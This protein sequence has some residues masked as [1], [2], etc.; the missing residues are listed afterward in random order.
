MKT[1]QDHEFDA[2]LRERLDQL[3]DVPAR[4]PEAV[5]QGR[6]NYLSKVQQLSV[7]MAAGNAKF[8]EKAIPVSGFARFNSW[9]LSLFREPFQQKRLSLAVALA[10]LVLTLALLLGSAGATVY[11]AQSSLPGDFLYP[12]KILSEDVLLDLT[13]DPQAQFE[14]LLDFSDRRVNEIVDLATQGKT[15]PT[16]L[17]SRLETQDDAAFL[18][19]TNMDASQKPELLL[20]AKIHKQNQDR[21]LGLTRANAP[22]QGIML[23]LQKRLQR[24]WLSG[25]DGEELQ[26]LQE[27]VDIQPDATAEP[28]AS[29]ASNENQP[30]PVDCPNCT[31][32]FN[33]SG[34]GPGP[35]PANQG[36]VTQPTEGYGP[37]PGS[38]QMAPPTEPSMDENRAGEPLGSPA[39]TPVPG[40]G[41]SGPSGEVSPPAPDSGGGS[42]DNGGGSGKP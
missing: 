27:P 32:V 38:G 31:P 10:T 16:Q 12:V 37:G 23:S 5:A 7:E 15:I 3:R 8:A 1:Q 33:G 24:H 9:I 6:V 40:E 25:V 30:G 42:H 2:G 35:G 26:N 4:N 11:A 20:K 29:P 14:L 22:D 13:S 17:I 36:E 28:V 21:D 18:L 39:A 41:G 34:P 19:F